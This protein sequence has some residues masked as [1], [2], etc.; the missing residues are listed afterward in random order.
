VTK[1]SHSPIKAIPVALGDGKFSKP[2]I[3]ISSFNVNG[4]RAILKK[5]DLI[6]YIKTREPDIICLNETKIDEETIK[7]ENIKQHFPSEYF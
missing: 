2:D 7:K 3:L 6:N 4:L 1:S 5:N